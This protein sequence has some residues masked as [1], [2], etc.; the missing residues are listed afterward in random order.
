MVHF[1]GFSRNRYFW[2][3]NELTLCDIIA[4]AGETNADQASP[5]AARPNVNIQTPDCGY[6]FISG[7]LVIVRY[8]EFSDGVM[9]SRFALR[10][11]NVFELMWC[12]TMLS[13]QNINQRWR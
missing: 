6:C 3:K 10:L 1:G 8:C 5:R 7:T 12:T 4:A 2:L 13:G 9:I 11:S